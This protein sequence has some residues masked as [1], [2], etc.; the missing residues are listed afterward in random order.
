MPKYTIAFDLTNQD[1]DD[2]CLTQ[3]YQD[4]INDAPNPETKDDFFQRLV[5]EFPGQ[6]IK[7]YRAMKAADA[8][9]T[10][11]LNKTINL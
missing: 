1:L 6:L 11:E 9:R 7:S 4:I 2:F 8:A 5:K 3:G 10:I